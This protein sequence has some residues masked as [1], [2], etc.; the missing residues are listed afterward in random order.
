MTVMRSNFHSMH[1]HGLKIWRWRV[2][3]GWWIRPV[4]GRRTSII[5][6]FTAALKEV[7]NGTGLI[8]ADVRTRVLPIVLVRFLRQR[9]GLY[10]LHEPRIGGRRGGGCHSH[11]RTP[12]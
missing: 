12:H 7:A 3:F 6:R 4:F 5:L 11:P 1:G 8:G 9:Q 10:E 2:N